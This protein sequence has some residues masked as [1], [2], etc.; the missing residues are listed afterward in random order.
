MNPIVLSN[1]LGTLATLR[2]TPLPKLV[3]G[4][5]GVNL[6]EVRMT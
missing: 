6:D 2:D 3:S 1:K 5:L 4:E